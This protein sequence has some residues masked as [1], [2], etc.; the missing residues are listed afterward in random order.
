MGLTE[1]TSDD[2][3]TRRDSGSLDW[4]VRLRAVLLAFAILVVAAPIGFYGELMYKSVYAFA[5]GA[6]YM[7]QWSHARVHM[8][9][10]RKCMPVIVAR[11]PE[12]PQRTVKSNRGR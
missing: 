10:R 2:Q 8:Y 6:P 3:R 7:K 1:T 12:L 9:V 5:S 11:P 4:P